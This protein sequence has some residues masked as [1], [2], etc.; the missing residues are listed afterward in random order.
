MMLNP[1]VLKNIST[2]LNHRQQRQKSIYNRTAKLLPKLKPGDTVRYQKGHVWK[3]AVVVGE[4]FSPHPYNIMTDTGATLRGNRCHLR[5]VRETP[6][7]AMLDFDDFS[8]DDDTSALGSGPP[9]ANPPVV[10]Q[11]TGLT[12]RCTRS[13]RIVRQ[14]L[15]FRGD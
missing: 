8:C 12:E 11:A 6:P 10:P 9:V 3:P 2:K 13:S 14:P 4:H 15:W 5:K 1:A 7:Q